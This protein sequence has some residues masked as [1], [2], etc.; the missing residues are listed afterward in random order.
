[1][2]KFT[3]INRNDRIH[4]AVSRDGTEIAG[5][6]VGQ[7]PPLV[8]V[9]AGLGDGKLDW[10]A[11]VP[12]LSERFTCYLMSTRGRG[13]SN[14]H[15]DHSFERLVED[16]T[17][18]VESIGEPVGLAGSSGGAIDALG[19]AAR[20]K[21]VAAVAVCDP[22][23][24]EVLGKEDEARLNKAIGRMAEL[25]EKGK[26]VEAARDWMT[27]WANDHEMA[28]L[29][30][31]G[32]LA[33]CAKYVLVLLHML[34]QAGD[35]DGPSPTDPSVLEQIK[36]PVLILQGSQAHATWPWFTESVRHIAKH[37]ANPQVR[38]VAGAGHMGAWVEPEP[39]TDELIRFFETALEPA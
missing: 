17:A 4:R 27:E 7:G 22:L 18:F 23:A 35:A 14:D 19:A 37:V 31:S 24:F 20:S 36:A 33:A 38:E 26:L 30:E 39:I 2:E 15:P 28:A 25:A 9:H 32:Y 11:A 6:V 16:V 8:L 5:S 34:K 10:D 1:M 21:A 3:S 29:S 13:L 12:F